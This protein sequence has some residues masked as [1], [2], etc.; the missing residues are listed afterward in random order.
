M[1]LGS[2]EENGQEE[3]KNNDT[4][5]LAEHASP[6]TELRGERLQGQEIWGC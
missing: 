2:Q 4:F 5:A 3:S 6:K 1:E